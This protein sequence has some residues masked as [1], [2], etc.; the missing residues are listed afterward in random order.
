MTS[1]FVVDKIKR[2]EKLTKDEQ[3]DLLLDLIN[4]F[5]L[6]TTDRDSALFVQDL[7]TKA[8]ASRMAKR[9]RI[10][11]LLLKGRSYEQIEN[12]LHTS[13]T[14][15]AKVASWL[16][17]K[18]EGFRNII[19]KLPKNEKAITWDNY[20]E[21]GKIKRKHPSYFWPELLLEEIVKS[22][23]IRQKKRLKSIVE[24]LEYKNKLHRSIEELMN[25]KY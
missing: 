4:A 3:N 17:E 14:T 20:S 25:K 23:S 10:A 2:L 24:N 6:I 5:M 7:F 16:E 15:I 8:E 21:W 9:L 12:E 22:A 19:K 13:H 11:K 1:M 18:G